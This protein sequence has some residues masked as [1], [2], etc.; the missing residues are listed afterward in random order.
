M[1]GSASLA[2]TGFNTNTNRWETFVPASYSGDVFAAGVPFT[3]PAGGLPGGIK[4]VT[5]TAELYSSK[6]GATLAWK[7]AAAVYKQFSTPDALG[8]K[9]IDGDKLNFYQNGDSA[10][11]PELFKSFV[12]GGARGNGGSNYTGSWSGDK[13]ANF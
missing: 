4:G 11:T 12:T 6:S 8:V 13:K 1:D 7:W 2:Q 5:W 9:P 10:G 3:V